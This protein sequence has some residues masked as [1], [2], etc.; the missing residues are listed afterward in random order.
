[1]VVVPGQCNETHIG[2]HIEI[3]AT[4]AVNWGRVET[5]FTI[6]HKKKS[7]VENKDQI[8]QKTLGGP[9]QREC[10]RSGCSSKTAKEF[11]SFF[12]LVM[13]VTAPYQA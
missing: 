10:L 7:V 12:F 1:M 11:L 2:K 13:R 5:W 6:C 3:I 4:T 8:K 9:K